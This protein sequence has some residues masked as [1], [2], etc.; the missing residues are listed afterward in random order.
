MSTFSQKVKFKK[1]DRIL[2]GN[3]PATILEWQLFDQQYGHRYKIELDK[4]EGRNKSR[5]KAVW[6]DSIVLDENEILNNITEVRKM[7]GTEESVQVTDFDFKLFLEEVIASN[8]HGLHGKTTKKE[9]I[10]KLR[11]YPHPLAKKWDNIGLNALLNYY[12]LRWIP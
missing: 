3:L 4:A 5:R 2:W 11:I 10:E 7:F 12:H 1:G 6:E 9:C 8:E